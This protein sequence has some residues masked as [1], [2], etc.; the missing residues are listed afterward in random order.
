MSKQIS[1]WW[2][3]DTEGDIAYNLESMKA[4]M[5]REGCGEVIHYIEDLLTSIRNTN[6]KI[7]NRLIDDPD[8]S[9]D[10]KR[11]SSEEYLISLL[12]DLDE[13]RENLNYLIDSVIHGGSYANRKYNVGE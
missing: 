12:S 3:K 11:F 7:Q 9:Q 2:R 10:S 4:D 5:G 13:K 1:A 6:D 8:L